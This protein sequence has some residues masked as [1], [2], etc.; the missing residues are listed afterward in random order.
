MQDDRIVE[1]YWQRSEEAI[2]HTDQKYGRYLMK[3]SYNILADW[4]ERKESVN[5][6]YLSAWKS[7]PPHRPSALL[8]YLCKITRQISIDVF[9]KRNSAKRQASEYALSLSELD[10]CVSV[11]NTTEQDVDLHLLAEAIQDYLAV[12]PEE[13]RDAFIGR[14]F[15]SDSI[16]EVAGYYGMSESKT[17]SMLYRTRIGLKKY[18]VQE[19]FLDET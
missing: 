2:Q 6:T 14:Y 4:K 15:F 3:L 10:D 1:L 16:R 17:K 11:G 19:G 18:L 13:T 9:R 7:M 12:L 5:D 8:T